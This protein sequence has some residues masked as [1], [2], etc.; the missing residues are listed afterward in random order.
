MAAWA[1]RPA[2]TQRTLPHL[3]RP[4]DVMTPDVIGVSPSAAAADIAAFTGLATLIVAATIALVVTDLKRIIAYSTMSQIGYMV[5]AVS[6][7]AY[8]AGIF[9]LMTHAFFK[10]LLFLAAGS[11]IIGMHHEQ[12][13]RHMGGLR[14]YLPITYWTSVIGT[15]ALIGFPGFSGFFS[16]DA[17]I[18]A[19]HASTTP[20]HT[21]AY[22]SVLL[23]VFVGLALARRQATPLDADAAHD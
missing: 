22:W 4:V 20:G 11:V 17:L 18:E 10:A 21:L 9:H 23:G 8:A 12:D 14:K 7:G 19:V 1:P 3:R 13:I 2:L 6:I 15:L 5:V 16:K